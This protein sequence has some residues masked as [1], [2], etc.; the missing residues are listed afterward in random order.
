MTLADHNNN[1]VSGV[2]VGLAALNGSSVINPDSAAGVATDS[3]GQATFQVTDTTSEIVRYRAT[4]IS[5]DLPLVGEE[6]QVTFGTPTPTPPALND[7]DITASAATVPANGSSGAT[8]V[9]LLNDGNGLP[10][11]SKTVT[12]VPT[13]LNAVVAPLTAVTDATGAA[14]FT[15]TDKKAE[16]VTFT[17]TDI[18]DNMPLTGLSVTITFTPSTASATTSG[19]S[20]TPN[21][22]VV[23][24]AATPDGQGYWLVAVGRGHLQ[25]RRRRLLRVG[26]SPPVDEPV[27]AMAA[28]PDG[29]GYWLVGSDGGIFNYGD[30]GFYGSPGSS[31]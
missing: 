3:T 12:L 28:T 4:D 17:A 1:P 7:S 2:M 9:V 25:L 14:S 30:A 11:D 19:T 27:V 13:S 8:V 20:P 21:K 23:G 22:S 18:T 10:L 16:S 26:G 29:K 6:V 15:V 5:D 24:T 31:P